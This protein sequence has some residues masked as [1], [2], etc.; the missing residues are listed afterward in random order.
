VLCCIRFPGFE[1]TPVLELRV[2][3]TSTDCTVEM[4]SCRIDARPAGQ[5]CPC[6]GG[7]VAEGLPFLG[8]AVA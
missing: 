4:L 7:A 1:V 2:A 6:P 5:A 8:S 3:L